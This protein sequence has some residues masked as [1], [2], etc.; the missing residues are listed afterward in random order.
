MRSLLRA[1]IGVLLVL[2]ALASST[3]AQ[4]GRRPVRFYVSTSQGS[5]MNSGL[6]FAVNAASNL[7]AVLERAPPQSI[8]YL[9]EGDVFETATAFRIPRANITLTTYTCRHSAKGQPPV[10][11]S[12]FYVEQVPKRQTIAFGYPLLVYDM[13]SYLNPIASFADKSYV[14]GVWDIKDRRYV[15]ARYPNLRDPIQLHGTSRS[16]FLYVA[17]HVNGLQFIPPADMKRLNDDYWV[18]ATLRIRK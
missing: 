11:T 17:R 3:S 10:L 9:C 12:A 13:S 8:I 5:P 2:L 4:A 18:N 15:R 7:T 6:G 1:L 14:W 16:E